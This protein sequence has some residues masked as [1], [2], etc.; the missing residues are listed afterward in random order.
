MYSYSRLAKF[1]DCPRAYWYRYVQRAKPRGRSI[2]AFMGERVHAILEKL[3]HHLARS[4]GRWPAID[5]VR[6]AY[7]RAWSKLRGSQ[8]VY[9]VRGNEED[10]RTLGWVCIENYAAAA[11]GVADHTVG[12]EEE[13][14]FNLGDVPMLGYV[15]RLEINGDVAT[16]HDYK[17]GKR[18]KSLE[19]VSRDHQMATY[20]AG[21]M[22][23]GRAKVARVSVWYLQAGVRRDTETEI[24]PDQL[25]RW[26]KSKVER[27]RAA[28]DADSWTA[29]PSP[30]CRW[31]EFAHLCP[32]ARR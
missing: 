25:T 9:V 32:S 23:T 24:T 29:Q 13:L 6:R 2:E 3:Y 26:A 30:L 15:D 1:D 22:A 17:T 27:I 16:V 11:R 18:A 7:N 4:G 5:S 10:Y 12:L 14:R 19:E 31:C 21:V 8:D 28:A 20:A